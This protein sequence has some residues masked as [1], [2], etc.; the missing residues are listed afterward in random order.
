MT[1]RAKKGRGRRR[2][3]R[4]DRLSG[5]P[6]EADGG[7]PR[8]SRSINNNNNNSSISSITSVS[9]IITVPSNTINII[10]SIDDIHSTTSIKP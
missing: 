6:R 7:A 4:R 9:T 5:L 2:G 3:G 1:I 10:H 8:E